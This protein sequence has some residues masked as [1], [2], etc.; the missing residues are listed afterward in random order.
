MT[1]TYQ[2]QTYPIDFSSVSIITGDFNQDSIVDLVVINY[3]PHTFSLM[4]GN[5]NGTFQIEKIYSTG[6]EF[7]LRPIAAGYFNNDTFL[8]LGKCLPI[9]G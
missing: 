3:D 2:F 8:D 4:L 6:N 7:G 1:F 5:G 9:G